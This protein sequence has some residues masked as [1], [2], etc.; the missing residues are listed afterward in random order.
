[1]YKDTAFRR[2]FQNRPHFFIREAHEIGNHQRTLVGNGFGGV[3]GGQSDDLHAGTVARFEAMEGILENNAV[4]Y[5]GIENLGTEQETFGVR[6]GVC[7]AFG[8]EDFIDHRRKFGMLTVNHTHLVEVGAGHN[9]HPDTPRT[10]HL[11][12][13]L[14]TRDELEAHRLLESDELGRNLCVQFGHIGKM[15]VEDLGQRLPLNHLSEVG[16]AQAILLALRIPMESVLT[17]CILNHPVEIEQGN[18]WGLFVH[19]IM[20]YV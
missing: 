5:L 20:Y 18:D 16:N 14:G 4:F 3:R 17:L 8:R 10:K 7:K 11:H 13:F 9:R 12:E 2:L 1:M 15:I 19:F 6:L